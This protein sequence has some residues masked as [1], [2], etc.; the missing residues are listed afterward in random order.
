MLMKQSEPAAAIS[1][2]IHAQQDNVCA[3]LENN[4]PTHFPHVGCYCWK[5]YLWE[6]RGS[7]AKFSTPLPRWS[8]PVINFACNL[9]GG[10]G[11]NASL[12][13]ISHSKTCL[14]VGWKS[15]LT[16]W[17]TRGWWKFCGMFFGVSFRWKFWEDKIQTTGPAWCTA[18]I[19]S[20]KGQSFSGKQL[21]F[22]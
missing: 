13:I 19:P 3:E 11:P 5:S 9:R 4:F 22:Q 12:F 2:N 10:G 15:L 8:Q 1:R 6:G 17:I 16:G 21:N 20:W 18:S 7:F 14:W